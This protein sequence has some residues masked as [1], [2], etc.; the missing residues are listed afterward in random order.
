MSIL[1]GATV[2][3]LSAVLRLVNARVSSQ[4]IKHEGGGRRAA[5]LFALASG[6]R[7]PYTLLHLEAISNYNAY[8]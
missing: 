8:Q 6:F 2:K 3:V 5:C 7:S 4:T 1:L